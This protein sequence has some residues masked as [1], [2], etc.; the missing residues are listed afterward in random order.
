MKIVTSAQMR[1]IDKEALNSYKIPGIVLMENAGIKVFKHLM[2]NGASYGKICFICGKGNNGGDGLAAARHLS[3]VNKDIVI[4]IAGDIESI[5]GDALVNYNIVKNMGLCIKNIRDGESLDSLKEDVKTCSLLVDGLLG[6]GI[7]GEV[8]GFFKGIIGVINTEAP[9][10]ISI[11]IPSGIDADTGEILGSSVKADMTVALE[12]PKIGLY[13]YPGAEYAG[14]VIVESISIPLE[15]IN[16]EDIKT[17]LLEGYDIRHLFKKRLKDTNK[18]TYGRAYIIGGSKNM[19][20]AVTM[21]GLSALRCGTGIVELGVPSSI[22]E[23]VAP[24]VMEAIVSGLSDIEGV[25]S[26]EALDT[27][28]QHLNMASGF[29]I[30]PGLSKNTGLL[31]LIENILNESRIHGVIDADGLNILSG[32]VGL[33]KKAKCTMVVTPHPGEMARLIGKD[34]KS[35]QCDRIGCARSFS[36]KYGTVTVLKGANTIVAAPHG[37]IFINTTG[38]PGMA[39]G[40]TGDIL[41]GMIA[42]FIAQ[43]FE[44]FDASKAGVYIHGLAGDMTAHDIGE[45]GFISRDLIEYIPYAIKRA[46][47]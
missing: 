10:V 26:N 37:E 22:Q 13:T 6:T 23:R 25:L 21:C 31:R 20:G 30:G 41:T 33:L 38:N 43:G 47:V 14:R 19:M 12:L 8:S 2:E 29:A 3:F 18:G 40:G 32:D 42:S 39:K 36:E 15:L 4:Y 35:I 16:R 34:I 1:E 28:L 11:D 46:T 27:L 7:I 45:Y 17:A 24:L 5:K 44:P 9:S